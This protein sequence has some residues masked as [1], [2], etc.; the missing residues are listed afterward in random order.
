MYQKNGSIFW[1][2]VLGMLSIFILRLILDSISLKLNNRVHN[3]FVYQLR[4]AVFDKYKKTPVSFIEKKEV[5][6][7]KMRM[8]DDID[9]LGNFIGDQIVSYIY[10]ILLLLFT[11][12]ASVRISW[13][14]T[15]FCFIILPIVFI[16]DSLIGNGTRIINEQIRDV[17]SKYYTSTYNSLQFWREIKAQGSEQL[18]IERFSGF[19]AVLAKL[20]VKSIRFWAYR[21]VFSDFKSNYLTKVLVYIIGAFFVAKN[22]IS[23]GTLIMFSEYFSM[24]FSSLESLNAKRIALKTNAPYYERVFDTFSFPE[25][26]KDTIDLKALKKGIR[27]NNVGFSYTEKAPVLKEISLEINKGDYVAIVGKT[28]CGKTTLAK[29]LLGLYEPQ[30]GD[31]LLDNINIKNVS[32]E[33]LSNLLGVVMQDNYLFNTAI[34][35]NLLIANESATEQEMIEACKKANIYDFILEQPKGFDT[36]IG[37]RGVKLSGGQKQRISIA[38]ALLRKPQVLI[39]DEAT[40]ALDSQSE[41]IINDAINRIS[42]DVTVIVIAHKPETVLR[43]KKVVVMEEGRI[44]AQGTH[45][46]LINN[47]EFYK[48]IM[49]DTYN[50]EREQAYS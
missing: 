2:V 26:S 23:V 5:G 9:V 4:K 31:I 20:G 7:L 46:E 41:D 32:R 44:V 39:F 18:F 47:N 1:V 10:G 8:M 36:V 22:Q 43:A 21:E 11:I 13:Q 37:E 24:L 15:L 34:R 42:A 19:R 38:A 6:E 16:V 30:A 48:N 29:L 17:N 45:E 28:G 49:E 3:S 27:L 12:A 40:S 25:E 50:E 35:E 33:D 14:M